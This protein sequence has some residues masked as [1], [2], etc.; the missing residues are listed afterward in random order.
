MCD[1]AQMQTMLVNTSEMLYA[2]AGP[3]GRGRMP[4]APCCM[5]RSGQ[6]GLL[7]SAA[8]AA[9]R[10]RASAMYQA[11]SKYLRT[12]AHWTSHSVLAMTTRGK[13]YHYLN[14]LVRN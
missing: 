6:W 2:W 11:P 4:S 1:I 10:A 12:F 9:S 14:F 5:L 13:Y 3:K 7:I 8:V